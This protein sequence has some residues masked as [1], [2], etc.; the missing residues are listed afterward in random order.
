MSTIYRTIIF[1][2]IMAIAACAS[3]QSTMNAANDEDQDIGL[4]GT[5]MLADSGSGLG[6]TG[7]LG[8]ITG[9]GSIFVNGIE[10]EYDDATAFA[11]DGKTAAH[12]QL[13]IGDVVEVLTTDASKHTRARAINLRHEVIGK[14]ESK[15]PQTF[16]FTV[17]GQ[18]VVQ[19]LDKRMLPEVGSTVAVSGFRVDE[20]TII[21]TRVTSV[22]TVQTLL[23]HH[24]ELPFS[25][26]TSQWLVQTY[27]KDEKAVFQHNGA[28]HVLTVKNRTT[29]TIMDYMA[30][31][32]LQLHSSDAGSD[33]L[34]LDQ[35][36]ESEN[37]PR[38]RPTLL[39]VQQPVI[40]TIPGSTQG[41]MPGSA[42]GV[43]PGA[44]QKNTQP[45]IRGNR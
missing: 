2:L 3:N 19:P 39:P 9:F 17:L 44:V 6:G 32:V 5:G 8:E 38:G 7:L 27:V 30:I 12:Q 15:D 16:S 18:T 26:K 42:Q 31:K 10:V 14:V 45:D 23:R 37:M 33:P 41:P 43:M 36:I 24:T 35:V 40:N 1:L 28:A 11:I 34:K 4:G 20:K 22:D 29:R 25:E 13:E 21:S